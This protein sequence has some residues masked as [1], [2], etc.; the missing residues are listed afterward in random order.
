ALLIRNGDADH[1]G[2]TSFAT[3]M[4]ESEAVTLCSTWNEPCHHS[5]A[6]ST[7]DCAF[8]PFGSTQSVERLVR[9]RA[10]RNSLSSEPTARAV[11]TDACPFVRSTLAVWIVTLLRPSRST[12]RSRNAV[13]SL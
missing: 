12:H 3:T 1:R 9:W 4:S 8:L 13:R 5:C 2:R 11:T 7:S 6:S 10:I